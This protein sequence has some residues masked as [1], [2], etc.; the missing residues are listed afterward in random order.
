MKEYIFKL[1]MMI[2]SIVTVAVV[3]NY[4]SSG[5]NQNEQFV[6][7]YYHWNWN[8]PNL[9]TL[10]NNIDNYSQCEDCTYSMSCDYTDDALNH[11]YKSLDV[12]TYDENGVLRHNS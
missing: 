5:L 9:I 11:C 4:Y 2:L 10:I 3:L 7:K 1:I 6:D 12:P 8:N